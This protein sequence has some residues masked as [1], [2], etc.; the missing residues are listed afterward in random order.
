MS[1]SH[2]ECCLCGAQGKLSFEHV[3][4]KAA[5]NDSR[6]VHTT[7]NKISD[8]GR[9][10]VV[11]PITGVQIQK[12]AGAYTLCETCN[13][14]TGSWYGSAYAEFARHVA[15]ALDV[16]PNS[17]T[18]KISCETA[19][20]RLLKQ[21][22][23]CFFSVNGSQLRHE[24]LQPLDD[25][26]L[27]KENCVLPDKWRIYAYATRSK[28]SRFCGLHI[29]GIVGTEQN[30]FF[31]EFVFSPLGFVLTWDSPSP[32]PDLIDITGFS[33]YSYNH[34]QNLTL[35][36]PVKVIDSAYPCDFRT[37]EEALSDFL[38]GDVQ[39][40]ALHIDR[41]LAP[42]SSMTLHIPLLAPSLF[43]G[44]TEP[45]SQ[46]PPPTLPTGDSPLDQYDHVLTVGVA[47][48]QIAGEQVSVVRLGNCSYNSK[49]CAWGYRGLNGIEAEIVGFYRCIDWLR[50]KSPEGKR[51]AI[52]ANVDVETLSRY[53]NHVLFV[54][55]VPAGDRIP[56]PEHFSLIQAWGGVSENLF[57]KLVEECQSEA[58]GNLA[59]LEGLEAEWIPEIFE[60]QRHNRVRDLPLMRLA[61]SDDGKQ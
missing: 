9:G 1:N 60:G 55:D 18:V 21:V 37:N 42:R 13:N 22:V 43:T 17:T 2:G 23:C 48:M 50:T 6:V 5:F 20:I 27:S 61:D 40:K 33:G 54:N 11:A 12:G 58:R 8:Q 14:N 44:V 39:K 15:D 59:F 4:P 41:D 51:T 38:K 24:R 7:L 16:S 57:Q 19:P 34:V 26:V 3:P 56:M 45:K 47:S 32:R 46:Q 49:I 29:Q 35:E 30:F 25:F 28:K 52:I 31:S 53:E 10:G 36:L